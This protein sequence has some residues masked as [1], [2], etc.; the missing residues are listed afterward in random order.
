MASRIPNRTPN[1]KDIPTPNVSDNLDAQ[2]AS[3]DEND[4]ALV[5]TEDEDD[6]RA[7][8]TVGGRGISGAAT[9]VSHRSFV[10]NVPRWVPSYLRDSISEL[11]KV[12]WP[13]RK[14]TVNLATVV[15][16]MGIF[17]AV[18]F[19]LLDIIFYDGLQWLIAHIH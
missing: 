7:V 16:V 18:L 2:E 11:L 13:S 15:V 1:R 3:L 8:D 10:E 12:T 6:V 17:F 19:G 5:A 4:L 14:D 9:T